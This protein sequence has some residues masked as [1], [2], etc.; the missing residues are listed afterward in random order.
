MDVIQRSSDVDYNVR[1]LDEEVNSD[2][3]FAD[4]Y[5]GS[6]DGLR[7]VTDSE[8]NVVCMAPKAV[9]EWLVGLINIYGKTTGG[10]NPTND[11]KP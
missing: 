10:V 9:A 2:D 1:V 4:F 3:T 6:V 11:V 8:C 7:M 5:N